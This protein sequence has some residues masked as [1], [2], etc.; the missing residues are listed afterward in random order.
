ML[1]WVL[2]LVFLVSC[3]FVLGFAQLGLDKWL[4]FFLKPY[5]FSGNVCSFW[6]NG[7]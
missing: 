7:T 6:E 5:Y 3:G 4:D 2:L 1:P